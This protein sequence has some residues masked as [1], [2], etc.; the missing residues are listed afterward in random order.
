MR[1]RA[2]PARRVRPSAKRPAD[3]AR[4]VRYLRGNPPGPS[5]VKHLYVA[6]ALALGAA[7]ASDNDVVV[8][9][10]ALGSQNLSTQTA[11]IAFDL[12]WENSWNLASN[13]GPGNY[14]GAVG[15]RTL[16]AHD[17]AGRLV[18]THELASA[19]GRETFEVPALGL[20]PGTYRLRV[21]H[22]AAGTQER[23]LAVAE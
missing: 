13:V 6:A 14:D 12:A 18:V 22:P 2:P 10:V 9:N 3:P 20:A 19:G 8:E 7:R 15:S 1:S 16:T 21:A 17:A 11:A 4:V 23:L 5:T